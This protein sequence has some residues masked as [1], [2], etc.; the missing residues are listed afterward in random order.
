MEINPDYKLDA[1]IPMSRAIV[2][3]PEILVQRTKGG[4]LKVLM[5]DSLSKYQA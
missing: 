3:V 5:S 4:V 2:V 1:S